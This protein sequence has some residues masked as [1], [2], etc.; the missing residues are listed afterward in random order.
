MGDLIISDQGA[1]SSRI[2]EDQRTRNIET[3]GNGGGNFIGTIPNLR[4]DLELVQETKQRMDI[5]QMNRTIRKMKNEITRLN[6]NDNYNHNPIM[7]VLEKRRNTIHEHREI[8]DVIDDKK[9]KDFQGNRIQTQWY[10]KMLLMNKI[11]INRLTIFKN[12]FLNLYI[13]KMFFLNIV[14]LLIN[15]LFIKSI[16]KYYCVWI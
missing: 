12:K 13:F 5:V 9:D 11:L 15:I 1:S 8:N 7:I 2:I 4:N 16:F 6:R 14:N 10:L 3:Q